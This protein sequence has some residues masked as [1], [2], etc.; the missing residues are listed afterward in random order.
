LSI[1]IS[2]DI[3]ER[4]SA[5][6]AGRTDFYGEYKIFPNQEPGTKQTGKAR[7][8][9]A[10]KQ[11]FTTEIWRAHL[12][13]ETTLGIIPIL[14]NG[15]CYFG[16]LD[17]D[18]AYLKEANQTPEFLAERAR[19]LEIPVIATYSK[20]RAVHLYLF[21]SEPMPAPEMIRHLKEFREALGLPDKIEIF[22]KQESFD[23]D[24]DGIGNWINLPFF[25]STRLLC[26]GDGDVGEFLMRAESAA[27]WFAATRKGDDEVEESEGIDSDDCPDP[28]EL[29]ERT[30][31]VLLGEI[32]G[33]KKAVE[34]RNDAAFCF[35]VWMRDYKYDRQC[36]LANIPA[37]V[38]GLN[39][40][41]PETPLYSADEAR[42]TFKSVYAKPARARWEPIPGAPASFVLSD[43]PTSKGGGVYY[44]SGTD[45]TK[46]GPKPKP[47]WVCSPLRVER[48]C[49]DIDTGEWYKRFWL[50]DSDWKE[51]YIALP[52]AEVQA[53]DWE[54]HL[55]ADSDFRVQEDKLLKLLL[56]KSIPDDRGGIATQP[57]WCGPGWNTFALTTK[58]SF[59]STQEI[60][61]LHGNDRLHVAGST[62][63]WIKEIGALCRGNNFLVFCANAAYA[64][65]LNPIIDIFGETNF[66][67]HYAGPSSKGKTTGLEVSGSV[68]GGTLAGGHY[69][70]GWDGTAAGIEMLCAMHNCLPFLLDELGTANADKLGKLIYSIFSGEG[71][72]RSNVRIELAKTKVWRVILQSTGEYT[73][74]SMLEGIGERIKAGQLVRLANIPVVLDPKKGVFEDFHTDECGASN[75]DEFASL[76]KERIRSCHGLPLRDF[77]SAFIKNRDNLLQ[78]FKER[79]QELQKLWA[80]EGTADE[81]PR[82]AQGFAIVA[83]AGEIASTLGVT[84]FTQEECVSS[85]HWMF[86]RCLAGHGT[87]SSM[88][89]ENH[90]NLVRK[91]VQK[92][93][94]SHFEN[95]DDT[96]REKQVIIQGSPTTILEPKDRPRLIVHAGYRKFYKDRTELWVK[97]EIFQKDICKDDDHATVAAELLKRGVLLAEEGQGYQARR[98]TPHEG[99]DRFY[100]LGYAALMLCKEPGSPNVRGPSTKDSGP[101]PVFC[102]QEVEG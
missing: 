33:P 34:G 29:I 67:F 82:V 21:S 23:P 49:K 94:L 15:T 90:I 76:I 2:D 37:L 31:K 96:H 52:A 85:A 63:R 19:D 101:I 60:F 46:P 18:L 61:L 99:R 59:G 8:V 98:S 93:L 32:K 91:Y 83:A 12:K 4:F 54:K 56:N 55:K 80:K 95:L 78:R 13:G 102:E 47:K 57:G 53:R 51:R 73:T 20:S 38:A 81:V 84:G 72:S 89:G 88:A 16:A 26:P 48:L 35:F 41:K 70:R 69:Y 74:T 68:A 1:P 28:A 64:S 58:E 44:I 5:L 42:K 7:T 17:I 9:D 92:N 36:A 66:G 6:F 50:R 62:E 87:G 22:P 14:D 10:R 11:P 40:A 75:G 65:V 24:D 86:K 25:G 100:V 77:L 3:I 97:S 27:Q 45:P 71:R 30:I 39:E 43:R 79:A